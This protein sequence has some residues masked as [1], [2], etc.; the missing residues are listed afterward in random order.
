MTVIIWFNLLLYLGNHVWL[1]GSFETLEQCQQR[2]AE[3]E[4]LHPGIAELMTC[5]WVRMERV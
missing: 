2:Q 1:L 4:Q 3:H 5:Q